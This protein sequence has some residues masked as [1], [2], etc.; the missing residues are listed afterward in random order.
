MVI[1]DI[2]YYANVERSLMDVKLVSVTPD[3]EKL[4]VYIARVSNPANQD[5]PEI[6]KLIQYL[7]K[8]NHFSPFEHA[9]MTVE[10]KTSRAIAAQLLRHRSFTFQEFSQR[11]SIATEFEKIELRKQAKKNRQSSEDVFDPTI[12]EDYSHY[13]ASSIISNALENLTVIYNRLLN[14][15]V[16]KEVA[17][18]I[19]PLATQTTLYMTGSIRSWIHYLNL[20]T[21][22]DVQLEHRQIAESIAGIFDQQ[23]PI[24]S[25]A[26]VLQKTEQETKDK[27]YKLFTEG[28]ILIPNDE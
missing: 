13:S 11:Y 24:I 1:I 16:A 27:L 17:R 4:I 12:F 18:M 8:H 21:K 6:A 19:L 14:A 9:H 28:K 25:A 15:G 7:I 5:N 26:L 3:A 10:I 22:E 2:S 20:R 23:F